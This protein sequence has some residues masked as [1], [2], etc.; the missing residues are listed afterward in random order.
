MRTTDVIRLVMKEK[1]VGVNALA[2]R[3]GKAQ[4][5]ISERLTKDN[6]SIKKLDEM[7]RV[8]DYKIVLVPAN[9]TVSEEKGEYVVE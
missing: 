9:R 3:L 2:K 1:G 5:A 6:I 8:L 4:T 7:L